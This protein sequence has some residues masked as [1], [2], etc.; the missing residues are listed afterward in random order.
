MGLGVFLTRY[1]ARFPDAVAGHIHHI[2]LATNTA[3]VSGDVFVGY[4]VACAYKA[5]MVVL[6]VG[7][8]AILF[9]VQTLQNAERGTRPRIK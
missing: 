5:S 2:R 1:A 9:L 7:L 8:F 3:K 6:F 4:G